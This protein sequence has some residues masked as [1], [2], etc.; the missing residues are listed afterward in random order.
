MLLK[1]FKLFRKVLFIPSLS[2]PRIEAML[3]SYH[4]KNRNMLKP[5]T[6]RKD[7]KAYHVKVESSKATKA[8]TIF[9]Y[10]SLK[11]ANYYLAGLVQNKEEFQKKNMISYEIKEVI[12]KCLLI[13]W[14]KNHLRK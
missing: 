9:L 10:C 6:G 1:N 5:L 2:D 3:K 11:N 8:Q 4:G 13:M 14:I 7:C 12:R